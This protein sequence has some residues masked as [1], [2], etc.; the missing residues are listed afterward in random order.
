MDTTI[1][2]KIKKI[3]PLFIVADLDRS[4]E[5]YIKKLGFD[6]DFRYEDFYLGII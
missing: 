6:V 1:Y 3:S 2:S 5:F 4:V